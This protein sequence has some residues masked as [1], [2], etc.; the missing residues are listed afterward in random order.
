MIRNR[1]RLAA[2]LLSLFLAL[3][4]TP[5]G[6]PA[7]ILLGGIVFHNQT[8]ET[9]YNIRVHVAKTQAFVHCSH[10]YAGGECSTTFQ[11]APYR[12]NPVIVSWELENRKL[13]TDEFYAILPTVVIPDKPATARVVVQRDRGVSVALVQ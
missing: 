2:S 1:T 8:N 5:A 6:K 9:I 12:G 3:S 10:V 4:C 7:P 11:V 13:E